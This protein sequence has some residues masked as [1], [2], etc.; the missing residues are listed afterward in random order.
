MT[1]ARP[2][3]P[4]QCTI[5]SQL[6]IDRSAFVRVLAEIGKL[7]DGILTRI[8]PLGTLCAAEQYLVESNMQELDAH[9]DSSVGEGWQ[10]IQRLHLGLL[11]H[12]MRMLIHRPMVVFTT[13]F[14]LNRE[15]QQH[16][17]GVIRLQESIDISMSSACNI[18]RF[19]QE[20]LGTRQPDARS[21]KSLASYLVAACITLLYQVLDPATAIAYAK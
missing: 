8:F 17:P 4:A 10:E 18:I 6:A 2:R 9:E 15:A 20:S 16:A 5:S 13:F 11:Y 21:D 7:V 3:F 1:A 14:D 19:A 12:T